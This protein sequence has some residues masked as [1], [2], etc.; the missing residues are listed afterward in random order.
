MALSFTNLLRK[1]RSTLT[2]GR[3]ERNSRRSRIRGAAICFRPGEEILEDRCLLSAGAL[4]L[5]FGGG[6]GIVTTRIGLRALAADLAILP[7]GRLV[8]AGGVDKAGVLDRKDFA[9][10]RYL[11]SGAL[12]TSFGGDGIVTT[13]FKRNYDHINAVV[14]QVDGKIIAGGL[15]DLDTRDDFV[16]NF[17]FAL[18]RYNVDGSLDTSFGGR[19][20]AGKIVMDLS[21]QNDGIVDLVLQADRKILAVG[22]SSG[23]IALARYHSNG[24]LDTSFGTNGVRILD[25]GGFESAQNVVIQPDGRIVISGLTNKSGSFDFVLARFNSVGVLDPT[26]G[27]AGIVTT[28]I[29]S[30]GISLDDRAYNLALQTNGQL[31]VAGDSGGQLVLG[32]YNT[33]GTL[34]TTFG[35]NQNGLVLTGMD[36]GDPSMAIDASGRI[37]AVGSSSSP[38]S[39]DPLGAWDMDISVARYLPNGGLD[40]TFGSNGVTT[41]DVS[42]TGDDAAR[43]VALD[44]NGQIVVAGGA[45][46][47]SSAGDFVL[48]R[49]QGG[50]PL[51]VSGLQS[52]QVAGMR[53]TGAQRDHTALVDQ[54]F[55][56]PV[57][58]HVANLF[59]ALLDEQLDSRRLWF[60]RRR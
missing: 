45:G 42:G 60:K 23:N 19:K 14:V 59:G 26:F 49:Y 4:D 51:P 3:L 35:T 55:H 9:L 39:P 15:T 21:S 38:A 17:A 33:D 7:D 11:P 47:S 54:V 46:F 30:G 48:V 8:A 6:D 58:H 50:A 36:K 34:D 2:P 1:L 16:S 27:I 41:T 44:S 57:D 18:A 31:V 25:L 40:L 12:D 32:R 24:T 56:Q 28:D 43:A 10:A 20:A 13:D 52:A 5:T 22:G 53:Q 29:Q 37:I